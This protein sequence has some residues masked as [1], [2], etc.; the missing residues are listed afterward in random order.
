[1]DSTRRG[2]RIRNRSIAAGRDP[3][4]PVLDSVARGQEEHTDAGLLGAEPLQYLQ[5]VE[6]GQ[7]DIQD[8]GVWLELASRPHGGRARGCR[9]DRPP[10]VPQHASHQLGQTGLIIDYQ[11]PDLRAVRLLVW[12]RSMSPGAGTRL[13]AVTL[14]AAARI[15]AR[16]RSL[17]ATDRARSCWCL[18]M[19]AVL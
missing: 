1:L 10:F 9:A 3:G 18:S 14:I 16:P 11:D 13:A 6:I 7:H 2:L 15:L 8:D 12:L 4:N 17:A 5:A 19:R